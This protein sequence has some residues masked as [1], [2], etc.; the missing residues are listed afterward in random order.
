MRLVPHELAVISPASSAVNRSISSSGT[1]K[2]TRPM[3]NASRPSTRRP[4]NI[5]RFAALMPTRS[6]SRTVIPHTGTRPH[7][8][9]VSAICADSAATKRSQPNASSR[10]PVKQ[11]PW[12]MAMVGWGRC[13]RASTVSDSKL[14]DGPRSPRAMASRSFPAQNDRPA[15]LSNTQPTVRSPAMS[16]RW[17]RNST[18]ESGV[19]ALSLSGRLRVSVATPSASARMTSWFGAIVRPLPL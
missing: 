10:P 19:S 16:D 11:C 8:P 7:F 12:I 15:P 6:G 14:A 3:A 4:V 17:S 9:W 18:N 5:K 1:Q 2:S 13:S